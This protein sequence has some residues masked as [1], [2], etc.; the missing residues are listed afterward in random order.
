MS[1]RKA[2]MPN[3]LKS[4]DYPGIFSAL[5][6]AI[7]FFPDKTAAT[8]KS[9]TLSQQPSSPS[10]LISGVSVY[11]SKY[12][13][14][15]TLKKFK[16][17]IKNIKAK[18]FVEIDHQQGAQS[19]GSSLPSNTLILFGKPQLGT[20]IMQKHPSMGLDLPLRVNIYE[21]HNKKAY[22]SFRTLS[23]IADQH[24]PKLE[25][26]TTLKPDKVL[27]KLIKNAKE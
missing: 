25:K 12:D 5:I 23:S 2:Y 18:I 14:N 4:C 10:T 6:C 20:P 17:G 11:P 21:D 1:L 27:W 15:T 7:L 22:I 9:P 8:D 26:K 19:I 24:T 16:Q 13:F 3:L